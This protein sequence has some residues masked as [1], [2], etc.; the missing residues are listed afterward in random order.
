VPVTISRLEE[1][2]QLPPIPLVDLESQLVSGLL[3]FIF[4]SPL[5]AGE[6]SPAQVASFLGPALIFFYLLSPPISI[7]PL[8]HHEIERI[9]VPVFWPSPPHP[10]VFPY[11]YFSCPNEQAVPMAV[12]Q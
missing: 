10:L 4:G 6:L 8:K 9:A 2:D 5:Q 7:S 11:R 3:R 12:C 1:V